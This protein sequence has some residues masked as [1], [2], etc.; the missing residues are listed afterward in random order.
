MGSVGG[1]G[2]VT[3]DLVCDDL[4]KERRR[5]TVTFE[6]LSDETPQHLP[7]VVAE[8]GSAVGVDHQGVRTDP[9]LGHRG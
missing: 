6:S 5:L 3:L 2:Q 7:T 1:G 9:D 8:G 4:T